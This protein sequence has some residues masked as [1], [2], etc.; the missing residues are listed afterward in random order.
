[1]TNAGILSLTICDKLDV[2]GTLGATSI[3]ITSSDI[4]WTLPPAGG[5][6]GRLD[7]NTKISWSA[8][9]RGTILQKN[10]W[11]LGLEGQ[12]M[13]VMPDLNSFLSLADG[14]F[15]YF[16][17]KNVMRYREWQFGLGLSYF[18]TRSCADISIVPYGAVTWSWV[19]FDT[20]NFQ[21]TRVDSLT[22][23]EIFSMKNSKLW[24]YAVGVTATF[25]VE[26]T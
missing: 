23:Y 21:F 20:F 5:V 18:L 24:G 10:R 8:G 15:T 17:D 2:F 14:R 1:M 12:F 9:A 26:A 3:S 16:N 7:W 4:S 25:F 19:R 6:E 22:P 11:A 13:Q